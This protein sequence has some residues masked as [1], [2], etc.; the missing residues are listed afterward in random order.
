[1]QYLNID[2]ENKEAFQFLEN[3][4]QKQNIFLTGKAGTGKTY[5]I[6]QLVKALESEKIIFVV[7]APTG[8]AALQAGGVTVHSLFRIAPSV[9]MPDDRNLKTLEGPAKTILQQAQ[10][11]IIDEASMLRADLLDAMDCVLRKT[12]ETNKPFAGKQIIAVGDAFQLPPVIQKDTQEGEILDKF[13]PNGTF[14]FNA[15]VWKKLGAK[16]VELQKVYRQQNDKVFINILNN[17]RIGIAND[18][19]LKVLNQQYING[20]NAPENTI[21]LTTTNKIALETNTKEL[22]KIKKNLHEFT[23]I[24]TGDFDEKL[25]PTEKILQLKEGAQVMFL[26]NNKEK[27]VCNGTIGTIQKIENGVIFIRLQ[28]GS[29]VDVIREEW[30]KNK[31]EY[32]PKS[33]T[34]EKIPLGIFTQFPLKLAWAITIHK[35][36]G[37]T[38]DKVC[39]NL[40][41]G[42]FA[43]GQTYVALSRCTSLSGLSLR[44]KLKLSDIMVDDNALAFYHQNFG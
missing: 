31:Y 27:N 44:K 37:L 12:F 40:G 22:E 4:D 16:C 23:A 2:L 34:I 33:N 26:K 13:Y 32:N 14:F 21:E 28:D 9:Y 19:D 38:F 30:T 35:S 43:C 11:I 25:Y 39:V 29:V 3:F 8:I 10:I 24:I 36:Q 6:E 1:M 41:T 18:D 5:I 42:A 17:I 7:V 15:K 20:N